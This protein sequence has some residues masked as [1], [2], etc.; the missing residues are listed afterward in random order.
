[1]TLE[2]V[3]IGIIVLIIMVLISNRYR[4]RVKR[5]GLNYIIILFRTGKFED[6]KEKTLK[7]LKAFPDSKEAW[8]MLGSIGLELDEI[9]L[10]EEGYS[11]ALKLDKTFDRALTGMG[12][13]MMYMQKFNDAE[14]YFYKALKINPNTYQAKSS[15]MLL[16]LYKG[17]HD[18]AI[19]LGEDSIKEGL[20]KVEAG[21]LGNLVVAYHLS[22][23]VEKRNKL[24]DYLREIEYKDLFF[25]KM[26]IDGE[27]GFY[28]I[29]ENRQ[30]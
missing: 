8:R 21:I 29:M 6:C 12:T 26:I 20:D 16:E 30:H 14:D 27:I 2:S 18:V 5:K 22:N 28:E 13:V 17:N 7:Y 3:L 10:A 25:T 19:A 11:K 24:F 1:M 23:E 4:R 15:L 9:K